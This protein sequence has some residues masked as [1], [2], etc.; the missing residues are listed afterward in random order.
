[1]PAQ[2][3]TPLETIQSFDSETQLLARNRV[4]MLFQLC[5]TA[6]PL[7][8]PQLHV[9]QHV[10]RNRKLEGSH[11]AVVFSWLAKV[12]TCPIKRDQLSVPH[13]NHR[14]ISNM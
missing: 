4:I 10:E 14:L 5:N 12:P 11:L 8:C 13:P 3:V 7:Q 1:M 6:K 9:C 2:V